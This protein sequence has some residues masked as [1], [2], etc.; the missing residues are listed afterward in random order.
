MKVSNLLGL[1]LICGSLFGQNTHQH[2]HHGH[3]GIIPCFT[4]EMHMQYMNE[5]RSYRE[6]FQQAQELVDAVQDRFE[7]SSYGTENNPY[8]I[9]VVVHVMWHSE[10]DNISDAQIEDAIRVLN[11]DFRRRNADAS[12]TRSIFQGVA[13]DM[14]IEF[15]LAKIDP[16]GNCTN[17]ITRTRTDLT[18]NAG[19]SVK[20][21]VAWDNFKYLNIWTVRSINSAS[22]QGTI[23]GYATF[24]NPNNRATSDGIVIR[25]D[26]MGSIGTSVSLG[27]TLTHEAGHIFNL[28]HPF[29][30]GCFTG[31]QCGDTPPALSANYGCNLGVNSCINDNPDLPDQIENYM[32]YASDAC[33]NMFTV[34]QRGRTHAVLNVPNLR[35]SLAS[36]A[37]LI[38]TGVEQPTITCAAAVDFTF[39]TGDV[40]AGQQVRFVNRSAI[41]PGQGYKWTFPGGNPSSSTDADPV[42]TYPTPGHYPV[43]LEITGVANPTKKEINQAISVRADYPEIFGPFFEGFENTTIPF[44]WH[45]DSRPGWAFEITEQ[46]AASGSKSAFLNNFDIRSQGVSVSLISPGIDMRWTQNLTLR[47]KIAYARSVAGPNNDQLRVATS[48]DCGVTWQTRSVRAGFLLATVTAPVSGPFLPTQASHWREETLILDDLAN[49]PEHVIV[50][51]EFVSGGGNNFYIDDIQLDMVLSDQAPI[52]P[53]AQFTVYPNPGDGNFNIS[54]SNSQASD[55]R[56]WLTDL[57]GRT[58][59]QEFIGHFEGGSHQVELH[60]QNQLS[61]G[62]YLLHFDNGA[63]L[64]TEKVSVK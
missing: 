18:I 62:L 49:N 16:D 55:V 6:G 5:D 20:Q 46:A 28:I 11:D 60:Y 36:A 29:Q 58:V 22:A 53:S 56:I 35:G 23:L 4:D 54:F 61:S 3:H 19:N 59:A 12:N 41:L 38:A 21:L 39:N 51:F 1:L 9:P 43:S 25:H 30:G 14:N 26:R 13:A 57:S 34:C 42:V 17:G 64:R 52:A 10:I 8:I 31:D 27:R 50:R 63:G 40:C 33:V 47:Y 2:S 15:R 24:P 7:Q 48:T 37:N 32:D 45:S 44:P